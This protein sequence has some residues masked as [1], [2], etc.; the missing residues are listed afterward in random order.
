MNIQY[1]YDQNCKNKLT[2]IHFLPIT[3]ENTTSLYI[4]SYL[5]LSF[6][7]EG[8]RLMT[9]TNSTTN[10]TT[11]FTY[12]ENGLRRTKTNSDGTATNY[13]YS[14][15]RLVTEINT[16][17]RNDFLYDERGLL[18]GFILNKSIIYFYVRD[19]FQNIVGVIN[20]SGTIVVSYEYDAYG[21][22]LSTTGSAASTVG[23]YNPFRYKGY[24]YDVET[25]LYWVSSRYYSSVLCRWISPDSIQYLDPESINGLN[26]Y[27]YC[28]N[29]PINKYDPTGRFGILA[30]VAITAASMLIGGT[31]QLLS[32]AMAGKTGS[33]LWRGVAGAAV[34][35]GVNALALC[36]AMP[37]GGASLFIAA[38]VSAIAQTGI[39]TLETVIRGEKVDGWQTVADLGINFVNTLAGNYLGGKMIPTNPGWLQTQKFLSVF[40]KSYGQKILLQTAIGAGLSGTVNFIR[41]NDW[42]KYKPIIPVPVLPLY[43]LF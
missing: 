14:G 24:Y 3:Y 39:D 36:L 25:Q 4:K 15:N 40:T 41:K 35:A 23:I 18:I 17:Y 5:N 28:G 42:S 34:G 16:N 33:E 9:V 10:V 12:D 8:N 19:I 26:L 30:L 1:D 37:T 27:A 20:N 43:T 38:G 13:Y 29:D 21:K 2:S 32:N 31:A 6:N 7:Y 11:S 22:L